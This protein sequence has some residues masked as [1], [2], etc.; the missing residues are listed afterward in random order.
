[1]FHVFI[2]FRYLAA[3]LGHVGQKQPEN[4]IE[5]TPPTEQ[6]A[7]SQSHAPKPSAQPSAAVPSNHV[8][9]VT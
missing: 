7:P 5:V 1:M 2:S 8:G 9:L 4:I 3:L 6:H